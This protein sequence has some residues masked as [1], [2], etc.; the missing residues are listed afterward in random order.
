MLDNEG[1]VPGSGFFRRATDGTSVVEWLY[2]LQSV[3]LITDP[4]SRE[5]ER[6]ALFIQHGAVDRRRSFNLHVGVGR[7]ECISMQR[8]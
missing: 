2:R 3:D 5:V 6:V 4:S 1:C 8:K 7:D